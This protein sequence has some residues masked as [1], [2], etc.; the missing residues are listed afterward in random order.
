MKVYTRTGDDGTTA[1]LFGGR[2]PKDAPGPSAYGV[3]A[4]FIGVFFYAVQIYCD[5]SGYSDMAIGSA[6]MLG[7]RLPLN[8]DRPYLSGNP[9]TFWR[10]WHI[11]CSDKC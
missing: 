5:F 4:T 1:L 11:Y 9:I 8:F 10:R 3:T 6:R 2:V 7:L